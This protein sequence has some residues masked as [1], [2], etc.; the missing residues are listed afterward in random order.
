MKWWDRRVS[1]VSGKDGDEAIAEAHL[2][3][4]RTPPVASLAGEIAASFRRRATKCCAAQS[5]EL[6]EVLVDEP[7]PELDPE[8]SDDDVDEDDA[9]PESFDAALESAPFEAT[10][11][12]PDRLS[13]L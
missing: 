2:A 11:L 1:D 9:E 5:D 10:R 13:V 4:S 12:E 3:R 7:E 8:E 6:D